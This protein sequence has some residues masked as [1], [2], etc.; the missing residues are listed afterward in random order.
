MRHRLDAVS[1]HRSRNYAS[2]EIA[3]SENSGRRAPLLDPSHQE[4]GA[5][6][7]L[8]E[9]GTS[10]VPPG[11]DGYNADLRRAVAWASVRE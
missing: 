3:S 10:A 1:R 7:A 11:P 6:E 2:D 8:G 4:Y 9:N 5:G